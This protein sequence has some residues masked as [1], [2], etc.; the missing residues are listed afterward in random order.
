MA[1]QMV[2]GLVRAFGDITPQLADDAFVAPGVVVIGDVTLHAGVGIWYNTVIRGD[3]NVVEIGSG[4]NVQDGCVLHTGRGPEHAL[5]IG[6]NVTI[7]HNVCAH[8]CTVEDE[9]L[10]GIGASILNGAVIRRHSYVAAGALVPPGMEVPSGV[11]AAGVPAKVVRELRQEELDDL[12]PS[13]ER[14]QEHARDHAAM[15]REGA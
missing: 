7:G 1:E 10:I 12:L 6:S 5:R 4:T 2:F 8:G 9:C 15:L 13:A 14:Y 11:L 3:I